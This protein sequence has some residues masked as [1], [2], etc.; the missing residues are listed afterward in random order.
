MTQFKCNNCGKTK[1]LMKI[2]LKE[3]NGKIVTIEA[4]CDCGE[5]MESEPTEGMPDLIRTEPS[6]EK[7]NDKLWA[8]TKEKFIG[9][10]SVNESFD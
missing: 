5:Y 8:E 10:R 7:R 9:E 2:T 1:E 6:L 4:L 3:V